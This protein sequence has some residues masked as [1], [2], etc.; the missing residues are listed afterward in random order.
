MAKPAWKKLFALAARIRKIGAVHGAAPQLP[1]F[2]DESVGTKKP[3]DLPGFS[4]RRSNRAR[5]LS[6]KVFPRGRVEVVVP[7]HAGAR[8][9]EEFVNDNTAWINKALASFALDYEP[10]TFAL[11]AKI[12]LPG[13]GRSVVVAYRPDPKLKSVRYRESGDTVVVY[14]PVE[15]EAQCVKALRRWLAAVARRELVP[16]LRQLSLQYNLPYKKTQ[17]R[18]QR[19]CWGS[20]SSTGTISINLCLLFVKPPVVRYLMVHELSHGRHMNHSRSF[21]ALVAKLEPGYRQLD[22]VLGDS[23]RCVPGWFGIY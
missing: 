20:R 15:D 18:A 10:E 7:R 6:I 3:G 16:Q 12:I 22:K 13:I 5:R 4:V 9:V 11:P 19:T 2:P 23:W 17:I 8:A 14:G 1:L 21:W